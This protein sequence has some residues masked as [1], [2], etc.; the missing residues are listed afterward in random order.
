MVSLEGTAKFNL[1]PESPGDL[2]PLFDQM[3]L[4]ATEVPVCFDEFFTTFPVLEL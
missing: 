4:I 3:E 1:L 2:R